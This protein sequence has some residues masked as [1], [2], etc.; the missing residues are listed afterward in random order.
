MKEMPTSM[1]AYLLCVVASGPQSDTW[2]A[3]PIDAH[4]VTVIK[5][6]DGEPRIPSYLGT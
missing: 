2:S 5:R 3:C 6:G 1:P 4:E